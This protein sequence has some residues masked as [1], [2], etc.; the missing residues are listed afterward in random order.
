[1]HSYID[2]L[3]AGGIVMGSRVSDMIVG[4]WKRYY[5]SKL[6]VQIEDQKQCDQMQACLCLRFIC[7]SPLSNVSMCLRFVCGS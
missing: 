2:E 1:M 6:R 3:E 5:R 4:I 7:E